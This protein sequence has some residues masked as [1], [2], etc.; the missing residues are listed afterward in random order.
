M[1]TAKETIVLNARVTASKQMV[2]DEEGKPI[3]S[4]YYITITGPDG[5]KAIINSGDKTY[6]AL[7]EMLKL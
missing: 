6:T 1:A 7:K 4:L 3:R 5:K 2:T